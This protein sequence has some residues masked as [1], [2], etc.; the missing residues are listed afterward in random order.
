ME[1]DLYLL[2]TIGFLW[3]SAQ[4][5]LQLRYAVVL[6]EVRRIYHEQDRNPPSSFTTQVGWLFFTTAM[7]SV[8]I[9]ITLS[10]MYHLIS[11]D[12]ITILAVIKFY[13]FN[14]V[15]F[16]YWVNIYG[17]VSERIVQVKSSSSYIVDDFTSG[18]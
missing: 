5:I 11:R 18:L 9:I 13:V 10:L 4:F 6:S 7:N 14:V 12:S 16:Y 15:L 1:I 3:A 17:K 2:W 8:D